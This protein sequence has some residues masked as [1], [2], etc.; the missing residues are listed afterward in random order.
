M[1]NL[2]ECIDVQDNNL[3]NELYTPSFIYN[4]TIDYPSEFIEENYIKNVK[5]LDNNTE[6]FLITNKNT[7]KLMKLNQSTSTSIE[8]VNF[9]CKDIFSIKESNYIYDYDMYLV[10]HINLI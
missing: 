5:M 4:S 1:E 2:N 8:G 3:T 6:I 7:M 9:N 10:Q